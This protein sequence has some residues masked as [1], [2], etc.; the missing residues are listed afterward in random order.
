M[1]VNILVTGRPGSGK[2]TLVVRIAESLAEM[3]Y[4]T[5]GFVTEEMRQDG[6]RVGFKVRDLVGGEAVLSHVSY[7]GFPRVGRYGVDVAVFESV[8]LRALRKGMKG[9]DLLVVDEVG[10]METLSPA[11]RSLMLDLME[12]EKPLLATIPL[13]RDSYIRT[14]LR[15]PGVTVFHITPANRDELKGVVEERLVRTLQTVKPCGETEG[16]KG[17]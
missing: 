8:A 6:T 17:P 14:L 1:A 5:A 7:A 11:F 10:R 2:T 12:G 16:G 13:A 4:K 9:A 3:G 15:R